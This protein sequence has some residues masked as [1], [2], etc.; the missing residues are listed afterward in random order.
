M[1]GNKENILIVEDEFIVANDLRLKLT[2]AGYQICGVASSVE[3]AKPLIASCDPTWVLLDIYL[4]DGSLGTELA[5]LLV[6]KNIG[7]IYISANTNQSV[8]ESAK[9]TQPYGF[10]VK[11]FREKDLLIMLDIARQKHQNNTDLSSQRE[12]IWK[13]QLENLTESVNDAEQKVT[14]LPGL[15]QSFISFDFM[16]INFKIQNNPGLQTYNFVRTSFDEYDFLNDQ[17]LN[18]QIDYK[19]NNN[20]APRIS[21]RQTNFYLNGIDYKRSLLDEVWEKRLSSYFNLNA[22]L[23]FR[24]EVGGSNYAE[25]SFYSKRAI[26]YSTNDLGLLERAQISFSGLF[27]ELIKKTFTGQSVPKSRQPEV[28][29]DWASTTPQPQPHRFDG[30]IGKSP[31]LLTVLDKID[32][33]APSV[34]SVLITGESGT[35][36]ERVAQCI[37]KLSP[38]HKKQMVIVNCAAL[39][40]DLVESELFGHEKGAFTGAFEKRV[41]KFEQADGGTLFLDE[42]GELPLSAQVKLLRV[43]QEMEF[44]RLGSSKTIKVDVRILAATNRNLEREVS[45]GRFRLD[46]YY[47][48]NVFPI[49][50]PPLR[51]RIDDIPLLAESFTEKFAKKMR[52]SSLKISNEALESLKLYDW[53]G[54]V[55]EL[56]HLIERSVLDAQDNEI[57]SVRIPNIRLSKPASDP[58]VVKI[59]KL[60]TLDENEAEHII[61]VLKA[62]QGRVAGVG[63]AAEILGVPPGTLY[64]RMKR[65]GIRREYDANQ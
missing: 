22:K 54:N 53:P 39:P 50:T 44:E 34:T 40:I 48:L 47:R 37:H 52:R 15:I 20:S 59:Q 23:N 10:L 55:R 3:E 13:R 11:P 2:K 30:I 36:K 28:I 6:E 26:A 35:G 61:E 63:G 49:E 46:L 56:E 7:F 42:V 45:E 24:I 62:V 18:K 5:P 41:G 32:V 60:K 21:S 12:L 58:P 4:Q 64:S 57:R 65:L 19:S 43:L 17:D 27:E 25:I 1:N 16:R 51:E 8:L 31:A 38:R 33:V 14:R 9:A 29:T